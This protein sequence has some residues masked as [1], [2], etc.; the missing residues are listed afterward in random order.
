M[1]IKIQGGGK[2]LYSN[3]GSCIGVTNYLQHEEL[4]RL[5]SG[6]LPEP[7][8]THNKDQVSAS[9][10][11]YKID[12]NKGQL[13]KTDSK[14]FVL[15]IS[16]SKE[17]IQKMGNTCAER[18]LNFKRYINEGVMEK[19]AQNFLKGLNKDDLMYYAKIHHARDE[20][21][22]D[23][24]HAHILVSRKDINNKIKL[25]PQTNH[26]GKSKGAVQSGFDRTSF[27][28]SCESVFDAGFNYQRDFKDTFEYQNTMKNGSL[29]DVVKLID[30]EKEHVHKLSEMVSIKEEPILNIEQSRGKGMSR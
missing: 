18:S 12:H 30:L 1:N 3:T 29:T 9:E 4:D 5:K 16:P 20:K 21:T 25:S 10:V 8:F 24:M 2:G 13:H 7:F 19:Y 27:F 14:F 26:R 17:E 6:Q 28:K 22:G 15:T 23:Q 11:T